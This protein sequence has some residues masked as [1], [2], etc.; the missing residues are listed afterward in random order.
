MATFK[1][2][3]RDA[4]L[5]GWLVMSVSKKS[6]LKREEIDAKGER[7]GEHKRLAQE[8]EASLLDVRASLSY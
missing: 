2:S 4:T 7:G 8:V 1:V 3:S 6:H 5:A